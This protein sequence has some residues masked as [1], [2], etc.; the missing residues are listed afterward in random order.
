MLAAAA[1]A[2]AVRPDADLLTAYARARG[3]DTIGASDDAARNYGELLTLA[4]G[5]IMLAQRAFGQAMLAGDRALA[6]RAARIIERDGALAPDGR[7][8]LM[9]EALRTRDRQ[10]A[11]AQ[12]AILDK[13][14]VFGL[15]TPVVRAWIRFDAGDHKTALNMLVPVTGNAAFAGYISEHHALMM[16][17]AGRE[18][19]GLIE[20]APLIASGGGR[21]N[22]LRIAAAAT[23][24]PHGKQD[25]A[26]ELLAG[27]APSLAAARA[28][29]A[30]RKP[31]PAPID[32][33]NAGI[34]EFLVRLAADL[35]AQNAASAG[36]TYARL[37]TF[38][39]PANAE[40]WLV[41]SDLLSRQDQ[42]D[43]AIAALDQVKADDPFFA[44]AQDTRIRLLSARGDKDAALARAAEV[45]RLPHANAT[46]WSRYGD[47]LVDMDRPAEAADAYAKAIA[48]SGGEP[49]WLLHLLRGSALDDAGRWPEAKA[50]LEAAYKAAPGEAVVLNYLG[51]AQLER[52]ENIEAAQKMIEE[53]SRLQPTDAAITDSLG[54]AYYLRGRTPQAIELLERAAAGNESDPAIHEHLGDAYYTAGRRYEARYAWR[55]ALVTAEEEKDS[56]R[57]R[58]K[59]DIGLT[60]ELAS[61]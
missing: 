8:L 24:S 3:A 19:E 20:L 39:D 7:F 13:D 17:A 29:L 22:R 15:L 51:Y 27:D 11:L 56:E 37:S 25:Q 40:A 16:I 41:T 9:V 10:G 42:A 38:L 61:P 58:R 12:L 36:L 21:A 14:P 5:D 46:D 53:A 57:L 55:A 45:A 43:Q 54:W 4:P 52:R 28:M 26:A 30:Q 34:A 49:P 60:P 18:E 44:A 23:L 33:G 59:I 50:S 35:S 6:L 47:L 31:L 1:P 48:L 2:G 32:S